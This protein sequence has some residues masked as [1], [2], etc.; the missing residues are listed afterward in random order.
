VQNQYLDLR[1]EDLHAGPEIGQKAEFEEIEAFLLDRLDPAKKHKKIPFKQLTRVHTEIE[2][3]PVSAA[4]GNAQTTLKS[5]L[6]FQHRCQ[7][8]T[9]GPLSL[10]RNLHDGQGI[11]NVDAERGL[12]WGWLKSRILRMNV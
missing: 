5:G 4:F 10:L 1:R 3:N 9:F 12:R 7:P 11:G 6:P 2:R 8:W